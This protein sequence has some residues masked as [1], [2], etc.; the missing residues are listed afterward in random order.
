MYL[1]CLSVY[2][3]MCLFMCL[4]VCLCVGLCVYV[5]VYVFVYVFVDDMEYLGPEFAKNTLQ[6]NVDTIV[7]LKRSVVVAAIMNVA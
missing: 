4:C 7:G 6:Q 2:V 3:F 5:S 1:H